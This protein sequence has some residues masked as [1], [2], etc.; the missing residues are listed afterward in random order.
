[1]LEPDGLNLV[2]ANGPGALQSVFHFH[3][4]VLP[5]R[6]GDELALNWGHRPG[7][8]ARVKAVYEKLEDCGAGVKLMI[9]D[10]CRNQ[11][12]KAR[13][14]TGFDGDSTPTPPKG[15]CALFGCS[16]GQSTVEVN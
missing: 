5:R 15:V 1:M 7:D 12:K 8:I 10:A 11:V 4:H 6:N 13:F 2:Q 16:A 9:V 14:R 3:L